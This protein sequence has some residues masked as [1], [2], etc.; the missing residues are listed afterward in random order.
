MYSEYESEF[1]SKNAK[2]C[3]HIGEWGTVTCKWWEYIGITSSILYLVLNGCTTIHSAHM[4]VYHL[5]KA[6][7]CILVQLPTTVELNN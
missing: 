3:M 4:E 2:G 6:T 7:C 5:F 1:S